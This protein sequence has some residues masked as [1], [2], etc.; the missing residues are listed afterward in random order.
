MSQRSDARAS[1]NFQFSILFCGVGVLG[2][3]LDFALR[4]MS[5]R[6]AK[7][8]RELLSINISINVF[9]MAMDGPEAA[10]E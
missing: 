8:P 2:W 5:I 10:F 4:A 9:G 3:A 7:H 1:L 6:G